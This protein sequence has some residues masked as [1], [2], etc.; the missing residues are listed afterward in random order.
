MS[1][2]ADQQASTQ[3]GA[4][5]LLIDDVRLVDA[6]R[7]IASGW[8]LADATGI[9]DL[10]AGTVP[11]VPAGCQRVAGA[12]R[13]L[14]PGLV[15]MHSHGAGGGSFDG[16][17]EEVATA[18]ATTAA[19]GVTRSML[20]LVTSSADDIVETLQS[21][22]AH[23]DKQASDAGADSEDPAGA[24]ILGV[25]LEGPFISPDKAGAH[26][27]A[28]MQHPTPEL[29]DRFAEAGGG[30]LRYFTIA[31]ELPGALESISHAAR[32]GIRMGVGHT[33][34]DYATT[35]A[36]FDAG[37]TLLT[38]AFNAMPGIHHREPGPIMAALDDERV[39]IELILDGVHVVEPVAAHLW[40]ACRGRLALITDAM[41][42]AG[43]GD[44]NYM[45]GKLA[46]TV[47]NGVTHLTGTD[48]IAGSTLTLDSALRRAIGLGVGL[49]EAT[50]AATSVPAASL[51]L[52]DRY[53]TLA[54]GQAADFVLWGDDMTVTGVFRD[55]REMRSER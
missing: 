13:V 3:P 41:S 37:A 7:D 55:G 48:T 15:D 31:P 40:Q 25:H 32:Q 19:H 21:I 18:L 50:A 27:V 12:G 51:G 52:A 28:L 53:G 9:L 49:Q 43:F 5:T 1:E 45:L 22:A 23:A 46:V 17:P 42:A 6:E 4:G 38:H 8:V 36:A 14:T 10:G 16:G 47:E 44:G 33:V 54:P 20:S 35:R 2:S 24:G 11:E 26:D 29:I 34:A 30:W 39:T